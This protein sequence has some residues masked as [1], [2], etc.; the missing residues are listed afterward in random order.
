MPLEIERKF[1]VTGDGWR[2]PEAAVRFEQGYLSRHPERSVRVRIEGTQGRLN[3]KSGR[4]A[5]TRLEY[6]YDLPLD[7]AQ[8]LLEQVCEQPRLIKERTRVEVSGKVWE[9]DEFFGANAGLIVA[10]IELSDEAEP[11][12]RPEWLGEEVSHDPRYL[13]IHLI[14]HPYST[15]SADA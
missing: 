9:V 3:I 6:E 2:R 15:W 4:S 1:L 10:E 5:L 13:N 7:E 8:E 14:D 12:E 11:F